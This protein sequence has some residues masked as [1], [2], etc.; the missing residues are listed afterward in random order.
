MP[1][2]SKKKKNDLNSKKFEENSVLRKKKE[3]Y[4]STYLWFSII[5]WRLISY[6]SQVLFTKFLTIGFQKITDLGDKTLV[7]Q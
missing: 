7:E 4:I 3:N 1:K 5:M 2:F 6:D